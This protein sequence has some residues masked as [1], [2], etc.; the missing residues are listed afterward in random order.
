M[1]NKHLLKSE[2]IK[3]DLTFNNLC[4]LL[5]ITR[6]T[7]YNKINNKTNFS[8]KEM[9]MLKKILNLTDTEFIDIFIGR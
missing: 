1:V 6:Q 9:Y 8:I 7:F 4:K 5:K 3:K 2:I